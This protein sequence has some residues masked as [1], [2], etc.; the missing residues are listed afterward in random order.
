MGRNAPKAKGGGRAKSSGKPGSRPS[1]P[2]KR[3]SSRALLPSYLTIYGFTFGFRDGPSMQRGCR[4]SYSRAL[5]VTSTSVI[6]VS[7]GSHATRPRFMS[8]MP[9]NI[10]D[11][12]RFPINYNLVSHDPH[13]RVCERRK[14]NLT[15]VYCLGDSYIVDSDFSI[16]NDIRM[17]VPLRQLDIFRFDK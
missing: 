10:A 15:L 4:L 8:A 1:M 17:P 5:P 12:L 9:Y 2:S 11:S 3:K 7:F 6:V 16:P 13:A 14:S